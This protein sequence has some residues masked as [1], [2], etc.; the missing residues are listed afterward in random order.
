MISHNH[1]GIFMSIKYVKG[2]IFSS[3][4]KNMNILIPHVCNDVGGWGSGFVL[5][6]SKFSK[7]PENQY[8]SWFKDNETSAITSNTDF[9]LGETQIVDCG[10]IQVANM[11]AQHKTISHGEMVPIRYWALTR[12]MMY[13]A[14]KM[15]QRTVVHASEIWCPHFG[16]GLACGRWDFI[17][18]LIKEIWVDAGIPVTVFEL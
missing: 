1:K 12:C 3:I 18:T 8:R 17:E 16:S 7:E 2:D 15:K 6:V 13:I 10:N 14:H 9:K 5:A 11:I 4:P